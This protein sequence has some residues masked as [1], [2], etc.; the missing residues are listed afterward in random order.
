M[1]GEEEDAR[2]ARKHI[3]RYGLLKDEN[4]EQRNMDQRTNNGKKKIQR[5]EQATKQNWSS[6]QNK[7]SV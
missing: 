5:E 2:Q 1:E 6:E 3:L 4:I 7:K